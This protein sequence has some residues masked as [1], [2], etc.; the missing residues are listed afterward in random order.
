VVV[1]ALFAAGITAPLAA[2][3]ANAGG[4]PTAILEY[5]DDPYEVHVTD[6]DGFEYNFYMGMELVPGDEVS[7]GASSAELR[8]VPNGSIIRMAPKTDFAVE[9]IQGRS[10][11]TQSAFRVNT[12]KIRAVA[13]KVTGANYEFRT[14]GAVGGVRGTDFG[15][16]VIPGEIES[17]FVREGS[18]EFSKAGGESVTIAAGQ[19]ANT[20]SQVFQAVP[21]PAGQMQQL[22]SGLQFQE[23]KP[24]SVPGQQ[25]SS[26]EQTQPAEEQ[27]AETETQ[28]TQP[29]TPEQEG[30]F[31]KAMSRV[32]EFLGMEIGA[33]TID[34]Q[35]YSKLILQPQFTV[36]KLKASLYL[37]FI[38]TN[39]LF[40][41]SDWYHPAG[42]DEWSFGMDYNWRSDPW[43]AVQDLATD[44]SLKI[45]YLEYAE[46]RDPFY[47][48]LGNLNDMTIGH[49]IVMRNYAN[50]SDFPAVRRLGINM[51]IDFGNAGFEAVVNDV[52]QPDIFGGRLYFRP[53][54]KLIP[55]AIG[56]TGIADINPA[57]VLP[58]DPASGATAATDLVRQADPAIV[59]TAVDFD[60]PIIER[61]ALSL[62]TFLDAAAL[63][64]YLREPVGSFGTGFQ[65]DAV[66]DRDRGKLHNYGTMAGV[67]GNVTF[68][69]YRLDF[70]TFN[71]V[72]HPF[73]FNGSYDRLRGN[74]AAQMYDFLLDPNGSQFSGQTM[75]VYGEAGF[76]LLRD[77]FTVKA[78]YL[79]PWYINSAGGFAYSDQDYL[80]V[81]AIVRE[82]LLPL[83]VHGSISYDRTGFMPTIMNK[84]DFKDAKLF[85][86][87]TVVTGEVIYPVAPSLDLALV[88]TT[89]VLRDESGNIRYDSNGQP[90]YG[91]SISIE[92]RIGF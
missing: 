10:G 59:G 66:W 57:G 55:L 79:W 86:A 63:I 22:F 3:S 61:D 36:G 62:V 82:G 47:I 14:P 44:L 35:T 8:L 78:G 5:F 45:R 29:A 65:T 75:G 43:N 56:F 92:S 88:V 16:Q 81:G 9:S 30:A 89:T 6:K 49:G 67:L 58:T 91:P 54:A 60:L 34:G 4:E 53:M 24:E 50:D 37:P 32:G 74:Y 1:I 12:G 27:P 69:D 64:P 41:S 51:G 17:L 7:T 33:V 46:Q 73:F 70:R 21:V 15:I 52:A 72:F 77:K 42:N 48:K 28:T 20:F 38:Y 84:G 2:Q 40:D 11:A 71:G 87:N 19:M 76:N 90:D 85:D 39:N 25:A 31:G 18:V 83:G 13:A 23:L 26:E 80:H 68:I